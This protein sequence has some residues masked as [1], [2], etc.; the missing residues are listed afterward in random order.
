MDR[1]GAMELRTLGKTGIKVSAVGL[2]GLFTSDI[3]GG[4]E[5]S[6]QVLRQA[7]ELGI[8]F[9]DTAPAYGNSE[10]TL[11]KALA[12]TPNTP[13]PLILSTKLGG[14]PQPFAAQ[15]PEHL[16]A[17][18]EESL[19]LLGRECIDV[20]IIHEP[21]RPQQ[22]NWWSD[23]QAVIGPVIGVMDRLKQQGKIRYTGVGG[24]TVNEMLHVINSGRFDVLLTAFN[25][26]VLY[27]EAA[28]ELLPAAERLGMGVL[29]GSAMQQGGLAK[30]YD[31]QLK[32]KPLWMSALR[33]RQFLEL[34]ALLDDTGLT[35]PEIGLRFAAAHP[36]VSS[37]L[38][39]TSNP[40]HIASAAADLA[41]GPLPDD[42]QARL[43]EIAA[44]VPY[45]PF[46]EPMVLPMD[47]LYFGPGRANVGMGVPVGK[48]L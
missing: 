3:G 16:T 41:R 39:G 11:G 17:S 36:A 40:R 35:L 46:E 32:T 45:R 43:D 7:F 13:E 15:N 21:D 6:K 42:V 26:S 47:K 29:I 4:V 2:G 25:Y 10:E 14:R 19:R 44:I 1:S 37:V 8:N 18:V 31:E 33:H 5:G 48:P 34:Y 28:L 12:D 20:L 38:V 9:I 23:P 27:R 24:T 22:Y 30:R